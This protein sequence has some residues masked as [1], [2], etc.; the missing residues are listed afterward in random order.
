VQ[1]LEQPQGVI[2]AILQL[3]DVTPQDQNADLRLVVDP[4]L[5]GMDA[6][7]ETLEFDENATNMV[8]ILK[9]TY[10]V[11]KGYLRAG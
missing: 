7:R 8:D 10:S 3:Q 5:A 2:Y 6:L 4:V 9:Q 11:L 1:N